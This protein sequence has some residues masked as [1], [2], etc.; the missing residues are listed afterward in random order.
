[1]DHDAY[2]HSIT[3]ECLKKSNHQLSD[4]GTYESQ[5][6]YNPYNLHMGQMTVYR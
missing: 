3:E 4:I 1:M 5:V 2:E 6:T